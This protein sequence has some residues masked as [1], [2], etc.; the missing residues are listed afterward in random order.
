MAIISFNA[1][2]FRALFSN[3]SNPVFY[4]DAK[5]QV[6]WDSASTYMT[7]IVQAGYLGMTL[8]RQ[9]LALNY[10]TAHL[11][12]ISDMVAAGNTPG[13]TTGAT[14][15]KVTVSIEAPPHLNQWQYWLQTTPYGQQL[16]ALMQTIGVGGYYFG[17]YPTSVAF[18]R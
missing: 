8:K 16:L 11:L 1:T 5:V 10:L 4:P 13:I 7:D 3:F 14:I 18:R 6:F 9:T 15:D 12:A 17:G 2:T